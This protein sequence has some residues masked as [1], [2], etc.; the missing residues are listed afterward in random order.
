MSKSMSPA[1]TFMP[2]SVRRRHDPGGG[3]VD[4]EAPERLAAR[5]SAAMSFCGT[6]HSRSLCRV[7]S[8]SVSP[9]RAG[10]SADGEARAA[11]EREEEL[12][13]GGEELGAVDVGEDLALPDGLPGEVRVDVLDVPV[14]PV[15]TWWI[16]G[17]S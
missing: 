6:S 14:E 15:L 1:F 3:R 9:S 10:P 2:G 16:L 11:L 17:S 7:A 8:T 5:S 12:L 4:R 13:L